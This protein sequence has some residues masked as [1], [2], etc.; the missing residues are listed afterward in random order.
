MYENHP[1]SGTLESRVIGCVHRPYSDL[2]NVVYNLSPVMASGTTPEPSTTV[3]E[4]I[5]CASTYFEHLLELE[6]F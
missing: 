3:G 6:H 5:A 2:N 1:L 4:Y